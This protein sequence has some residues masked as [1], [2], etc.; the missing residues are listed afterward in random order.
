MIKFLKVFTLVCLTAGLLSACSG[1]PHKKECPKKQ[2]QT[3]CTAN[4][5]NCIS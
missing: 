3:A 2:H 4:D 5:T 1:C